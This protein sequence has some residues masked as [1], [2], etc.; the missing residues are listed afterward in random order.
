MRYVDMPRL[1]THKFRV[2]NIATSPCHPT[3]AF[4][5][6][7]NPPNFALKQKPKHQHPPKKLIVK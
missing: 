2:N 5:L 1:V 7:A 3:R 4:T 6:R